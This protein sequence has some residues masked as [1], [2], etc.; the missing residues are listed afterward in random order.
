MAETIQVAPEDWL[1]TPLR[2]TRLGAEIT[3]GY[4]KPS[5]TKQGPGFAFASLNWV[6]STDLIPE[7]SEP[8]LIGV[9]RKFF[10]RVKEGG[11]GKGG[12][13]GGGGGEGGA[14]HLK[15]LASGDTVKV[16]DQI[17]VRLGV[18][19]RSQFEY[20]HLKDPKGAG[21]EAETLRSGWSW[22]QLARYEEPRDSLTN[23]FIQWLPHGE[24]VLKYRV[25]PTTPGRYKIGAAVLQSMY[26][27]EFAAHS[28]GFELAVEE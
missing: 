8:G 4:A 15:P 19:T 28:A 6:Y 7:P 24:Y 5:I 23:F 17:E 1:K 12:N 18:A 2:W 3:P 26:A 16:G 9:S 10:L 11:G 27:P 13:G 22:D 14:Y 20:V 21:F 25:R